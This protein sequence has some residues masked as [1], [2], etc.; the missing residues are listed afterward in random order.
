MTKNIVLENASQNGMKLSIWYEGKKMWAPYDFFCGWIAP[1]SLLWVRKQNFPFLQFVTR[2]AEKK[3]SSSVMPAWPM[4]W[5]M[6]WIP[7]NVNHH[8]HCVGNISRKQSIWFLNRHQT[9]PFLNIKGDPHHHDPS[10]KPQLCGDT[11]T[12]NTHT[13]DNATYVLIV[14]WDSLGVF[15]IC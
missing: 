9:T 6:S 5:H 13:P 12:Y 7:L 8:R 4:C 11:K 14:E 10:T 1:R 3:S 2:W 15:E